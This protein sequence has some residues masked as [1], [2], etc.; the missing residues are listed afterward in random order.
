MSFGSSPHM[1]GTDVN[2]VN[3]VDNKMLP[4]AMVSPDDHL[5]PQNLQSFYRKVN[6][7]P[8]P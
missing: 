2:N 1:S 5:S 8:P 4:K 7:R 6:L 3:A